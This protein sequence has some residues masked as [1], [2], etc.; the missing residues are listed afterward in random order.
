MN[1]SSPAAMIRRDREVLVISAVVIILTLIFRVRE[2]REVYVGGLEDYPLPPLCMSYALFGVKCPGCG[3]TRSLIYLAHGDW[4]GSWRMHRLG[5]LF[6]AV[7]LVQIPYRLWSLRHGGRPSFGV[8]LPTCF[9][10]VLI[11]LLMANWVFD[12]ARS[13]CFAA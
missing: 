7:I 11:W 9:G 12:L 3:L 8:W 10:Y 13:I 5:I 1:C 4:A 2:D 6:G